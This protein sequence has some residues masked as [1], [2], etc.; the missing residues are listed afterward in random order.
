MDDFTRDFSLASVPVLLVGCV[1]HPAH[2][3]LPADRGG[4]VSLVEGG[5]V[6][7]SQHVDIAVTIECRNKRKSVVLPLLLPW[8]LS[9]EDRDRAIDEAIESLLIVHQKLDHLPKEEGTAREESY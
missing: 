8:S 4:C 1:L 6:N 7:I 3:D 5:R 9:G 2:C